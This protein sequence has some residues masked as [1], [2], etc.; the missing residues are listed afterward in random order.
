V[1][2]GAVAVLAATRPGKDQEVGIAVFPDG[3]KLVILDKTI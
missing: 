1:N 2:V 3:S